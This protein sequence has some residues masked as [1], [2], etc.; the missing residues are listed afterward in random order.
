MLVE[1][2]KLIMSFLNKQTKLEV[3]DLNCCYNMF[4]STPEH[5][6][7]KFKLK[8]LKLNDMM[9]Y[10]K[11]Q[12]T[13]LLSSMTDSVTSLEIGIDMGRDITNYALKN[14]VNL[15]SLTIDCD[16]LP[17]SPSFYNDMKTSQTLKTVEIGG[18]MEKTMSVLQFLEHHPDIE[19]LDLSAVFNLPTTR[20]SFWSRFAGVTEKVRSLK[21]DTLDAD[22][23]RYIK[24]KN[25][26][27]FKTYSL[28]FIDINDWIEFCR[29][30]PNIER[31]YVYGTDDSFNV[32][33]VKTVL[34]QNLPKLKDFSADYQLE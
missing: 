13:N 32:N 9:D 31:F 23:V 33:D 5:L 28:E 14:F 24:S 4:Q 8:E 22:N 30:N 2:Q 1:D 26:K 6:D 15:E 34:T 20:Y 11:A 18:E 10:D 7:P 3:L 21:L 19:S 16:S 25:L 27:E 12:M 29:N 17:N